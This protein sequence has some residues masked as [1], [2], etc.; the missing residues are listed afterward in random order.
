MNQTCFYCWEKNSIDNTHCNLCGK[1]LRNKNRQYNK[2]II[3]NLYKDNGYLLKNAFYG[4]LYSEKLLYEEFNINRGYCELFLQMMDDI[5]KCL[6][7][8][9]TIKSNDLS[10]MDSDGRIIS[11]NDFNTDVNDINYN[12]IKLFPLNYLM[13]V[14]SEITD[15][16]EEYKKAYAEHFA[17]F[18][19]LNNH[20]N[21]D[22]FNVYTF[23][24]KFYRYFLK[25]H[26][27]KKINEQESLSDLMKFVFPIVSGGVFTD[28]IKDPEIINQIN[29]FREDEFLKKLFTNSNEIN[30][31]DLKKTKGI[32]NTLYSVVFSLNKNSFKE[33]MDTALEL[34]NELYLT[35]PLTG[36]FCGIYYRLDLDSNIN[37]KDSLKNYAEI[38]EYLNNFE[39]YILKEQIRNVIKYTDFFDKVNTQSFYKKGHIYPSYPHEIFN[40]QWSVKH[41]IY[42]NDVNFKKHDLWVKYKMD[43]NEFINDVDFHG[44]KLAL[45]EYANLESRWLEGMTAKCV[46]EKAYY[47][48]L[49]RFEE[50]YDFLELKSLTIPKIGKDAK[51]GFKYDYITCFEPK[52]KNNQTQDIEANNKPE[53]EFNPKQSKIA[54]NTENFEYLD[55]LIKSGKNEIYLDAD[56][57]LG[58]DEK[59]VYPDGIEINGDIIIDGNNHTID[60]KEKT[61][62][63]N[64]HGQNIVLKNLYL[65]NGYVDKRGGALYIDKGT[66]VRLINDT[67][68]NNFSFFKGG[69]IYSKGNLDI[70]HCRFERN[71]AKDFGGAIYIKKE[72]LEIKSAEFY[73]NGVDGYGG[74]IYIDCESETRIINSEFEKNVSN[75]GSG[76]LEGSGNAHIQNTKFLNN[77]GFRSDIISLAGLSSLSLEN[78]TFKGNKPRDLTNTKSIKNNLSKT[79]SLRKLKKDNIIG[80]VTFHYK[81]HYVK[82]LFEIT[83]N[84]VLI[85]PSFIPIYYSNEEI[86]D[87]DY[88]KLNETICENSDKIR[89]IIEDNAR[90]LDKNFRVSEDFYFN[91]N[92]NFT[93]N[94][95]RK[96]LFRFDNSEEIWFYQITSWDGWFI[97]LLEPFT[98]FNKSK[99]FK[100][101]P[102]K[103]LIYDNINEI[104]KIILKFYHLDRYYRFIDN[105]REL[106]EE[107]R[108]KKLHHTFDNDLEMIINPD[109][110]EF[111]YDDYYYKKLDV[112]SIPKDARE[113]HFIHKPKKEVNSKK[114]K[115]NSN[116]APKK[117]I[118]NPDSE[119]AI[120]KLLENHKEENIVTIVGG[121]YNEDL[122]ENGS[123]FRIVKEPDNP[124]D[125]EAIAVKHDDET[126][127]Y[128]ANSVSTVVK[129]TMSAGR[130]YDKFNNNGKIEI[131]YVGGRIIAKLIS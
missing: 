125:A 82:S 123:V 102:I 66:Q 78:C 97:K 29:A 42:G 128:V 39:N 100:D 56:I 33:S 61:R 101:T 105:W 104:G 3:S 96:V 113:S 130:I 2:K 17:Y 120:N 93:G 74:A 50:Y 52:P 14:D 36:I 24:S 60:A 86:N 7:D 64:I 115:T 4:L 72:P 59:S 16:D 51:Y 65:K 91:L 34:E 46:S 129:G 85:S 30:K 38:D 95:I 15:I 31:N 127:A 19:I 22:Y 5:I 107:Y 111:D 55:N 12:L 44:L 121:F 112:I 71:N 77:G 73:D 37:F 63:F 28:Y 126:I 8:S 68:E 25:N 81:K 69:A 76:V 87:N 20:N 118:K 124:Y 103:S 45:I 122:F 9:T 1:P 70:K 43:L 58:G 6:N 54:G 117:K 67:F 18:P 48:M 62:I 94:T 109:E 89:E 26:T 53:N 57:I 23:I 84:N 99:L 49:L 80:D 21:R 13:K 106:L 110:G 35:V 116:R 83:N 40:F 114:R 92:S 41:M 108:Y 131:I 88:I 47:K 75:N 27:Y 98:E 32:M 11:L 79:Y 90:V 119:S 10:K